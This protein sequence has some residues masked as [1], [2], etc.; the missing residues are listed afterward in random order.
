MLAN[1]DA[2]KEMMLKKI[3]YH[4]KNLDRGK[5]TSFIDIYLQRMKEEEQNGQGS[6]NSSFRGQF[7]ILFIEN[8]SG[9]WRPKTKQIHERSFPA[10]QAGRDTVLVIVHSCNRM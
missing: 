10:E 6:A 1:R 2:G 4:R 5:L 8:A 9:F 3:D 7:V